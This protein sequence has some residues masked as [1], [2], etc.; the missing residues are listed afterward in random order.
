MT[1]SRSFTAGVSVIY[2]E[3]SMDHSEEISSLYREPTGTQRL[4]AR[5]LKDKIRH[6]TAKAGVVGLGYVGLPLAIEMAHAGFEV[7]GMDLVR[8]RVDSVNSGISYIPDVAGET[9]LS[10]VSGNKMRATQSLA[11]AEKLDTI[12]IC[13]PTPLRKNKGPDLS[14]VIAAV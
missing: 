8:E 11:A 10:L 13:V 3:V 6:R 12:N 2:Q 1:G 4:L 9:L 5:D 14:Y 7:T